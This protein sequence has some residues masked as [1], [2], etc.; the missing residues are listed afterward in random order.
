MLQMRDKKGYVRIAVAIFLLVFLLFPIYWMVHTSLMPTSAILS[1][2]PKILLDPTLINFFSYVDVFIRKPIVQWFRN[3][4]VVTIGS[5]TV[6]VVVSLFAGYSLSRYSTFGQQL[7][8]YILL[9]SRMLPGALLVI[10]LYIIFSRM[11]LINSLIAL[12]A[13]NVTAII[14]FTTWMMKGFFDGI[15]TELE[16]S[17]LIDGCSWFDSFYYIVLPLTVPG[18]AAVIIYS[19]ILSWNE[20]L[21]ARTLAYDPGAWIFTVGIASFV[22]EHSVSWSG[23]MAAGT[24]FIIPIIFLFFFLEPYLVRGLTAGAI[25]E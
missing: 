22:G 5:A 4:L 16:E 9:L 25:K 7:M 12:M 1:V 11:G 24:I 21:F 10:P 6:S 18:L 2:E 17:G 15:P 19:A 23:L 14:P 8:G 20:Y 13:A 3:S